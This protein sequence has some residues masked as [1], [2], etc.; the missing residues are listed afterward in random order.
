[1]K[2]LEKIAS[3]RDE[4]LRK[5]QLTEYLENESII[6]PLNPKKEFTANAKLAQLQSIIQPMEKYWEFVETETRGSRSQVKITKKGK[7]ALRIFGIPK[8]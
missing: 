2:V 6:K 3:Y 7:Q 1:M 5:W 4:M 8:N